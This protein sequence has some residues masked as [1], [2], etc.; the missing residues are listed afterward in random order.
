MNSFNKN[1]YNNYTNG[2]SLKDLMT[3]PPM[4]SEQHSKLMRRRSER[5]RAVEAREELKTATSC[6]WE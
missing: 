6:C 4:T 5:R 1:W 3:A 2:A